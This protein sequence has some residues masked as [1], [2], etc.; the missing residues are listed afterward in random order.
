M[1]DL[2]KRLIKEEIKDGKVICDSC[3]WSWDLSD[4]GKDKYV[5]HKCGHDNT[6][7]SN[8]DTIFDQFKTKFPAQY[9]DKLDVIKDFIIKY[10]SKNGFKIKLLKS[11]YTGFSGV[12]T[13]DQIIICS[14]NEMQTLGAFVYTLFHEMRHESQISKIKMSNPLSDFDLEDFENLYKQYWEMELDADQFAKNMVAKLVRDLGIPMDIA[15]KELV[16][17]PYILNYPSM[18]KMIEQN[19]RKI[20]EEIKEMKRKG[21]KYDDIQDHPVVKPFLKNLENLF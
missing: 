8:L 10:I 7:K 4:G 6:P 1:R 13:K 15:K 17:S 18:S 9:V 3:G 2:I 16:L 20:T 21:E 14:P 12:R 11:C 19:L 5:C